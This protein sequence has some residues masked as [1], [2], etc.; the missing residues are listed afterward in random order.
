MSERQAYDFEWAVEYEWSTWLPSGSARGW[1][2]WLKGFDERDSERAA[3]EL[4]RQ[5]TEPLFTAG[6]SPIPSG[7]APEAD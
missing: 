6:G 3:R 4:C 2:R 7:E 1:S 5:M